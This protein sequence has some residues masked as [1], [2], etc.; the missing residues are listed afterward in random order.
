V[1]TSPERFVKYGDPETFSWFLIGFGSPQRQRVAH[2]GV[3][4][5]AAAVCGARGDRYGTA[6]EQDWAEESWYDLQGDGIWRC[7]R[8][9]DKWATY[10]E[11]ESG[12]RPPTGPPGRMK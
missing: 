10:H 4:I 12:H 7:A 1:T 3:R 11:T 2:W 6:F 9:E 8:C 5:D